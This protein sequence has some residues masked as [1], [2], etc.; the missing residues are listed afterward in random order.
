M[1]MLQF[2]QIN[3]LKLTQWAGIALGALG[4]FLSIR[5]GGA[6][7]ER[8]KQHEKA[9]RIRNDMANVPDFDDRATSE[10]LRNGKF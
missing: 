5:K 9:D 1:N 8:V 4:L 2:L 10:R 6:D 7:A 3:W